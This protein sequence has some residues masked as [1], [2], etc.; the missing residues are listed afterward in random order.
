MEG[1][2]ADQHPVCYLVSTDSDTSTGTT[3][4]PNPSLRAAAGG[5]LSKP[6]GQLEPNWQLNPW[7]CQTGQHHPS[8]EPFAE[9]PWHSGTSVDERCQPDRLLVHR[10]ADGLFWID[11]FQFN[12]QIIPAS[13]LPLAS[14]RED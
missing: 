1:P 4:K 5:D 10:A 7:S 3:H 2:H 13:P 8:L 12:L 14:I 11:R 9:E 6:L